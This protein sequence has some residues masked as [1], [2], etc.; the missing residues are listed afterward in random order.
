MNTD[1]VL[2]ILE[3][4][5]T[6]NTKFLRSY[7]SQNRFG[8]IGI[9]PSTKDFKGFEIQSA[10][11]QN[12]EDAC[13]RDGLKNC[14]KIN[15]ESDD[16]VISDE[17]GARFGFIVTTVQKPN[18]YTM[19]SIK[20][21]DQILTF[22]TD[23]ITTKD[24]ITL[25][26]PKQLITKADEMLDFVMGLFKEAP[27][28]TVDEDKS[29]S[30]ADAG[31]NESN[32][33]AELEAK[34]KAELEAQE[35]AEL[36]AKRKA[37][38]EAQEKAEL[39][40]QEKTELEA[41]AQAL[42]P[43]DKNIGTALGR[44]GELFVKLG[45]VISGK[46]VESTSASSSQ[47][48]SKA[49]NTTNTPEIASVSSSSQTSS[50]STDTDGLDLNVVLEDSTS[51]KP[52]PAVAVPKS[53]PT[54]TPAAAPIAAPAA[55]PIAAPATAPAT[56]PAAT[57]KGTKQ[58]VPPRKPSARIAN[59]AKEA[60]KEMAKLSETINKQKGKK[61]ENQ[62]PPI[63]EFEDKDSEYNAIVNEIGEIPGQIFK[64]GSVKGG[65]IFDLNLGT[66]DTLKAFIKETQAY[67]YREPLF[68]GL[69]ALNTANFNAIDPAQR[70]A[71]LEFVTVDM[72][73][74]NK[75][76]DDTSKSPLMQE[77][78]QTIRNAI[79]SKHTIL[80]DRLKAIDQASITDR[81]FCHI[82]D[83][84][85][86]YYALLNNT[87]LDALSKS[88]IPIE[89][90]QRLYIN[91]YM[92]ILASKFDKYSAHINAIKKINGSVPNE[93]SAYEILIQ[94]NT[95]KI[96]EQDKTKLV[97]FLK[98]A[99]HKIK[100]ILEKRATPVSNYNKRFNL[101]FD[102][103][104][105]P[106][107]LF[108]QYRNTKSPFYNDD[109]IIS[110]SSK[111]SITDQFVF[112][113]YNRILL[114]FN[115]VGATNTY[116]S[117]KDDADLISSELTKS[118]IN[119]KPIFIIGYGRSGSGKTTSLIY[120]NVENIKGEGNPGILIELL[121]DIIRNN[122][123][124][125][126]INVQ[127]KEFGSNGKSE[128]STESVTTAISNDRTVPDDFIG[129]LKDKMNQR[130]IKATTNNIVSSRS[131]LIIHIQ[132]TGN[133]D[134]KPINLFIGDFAGI[135][136]EFQ[137]SSAQDFLRLLKLKKNYYYIDEI[138]RSLGKFPF[139]LIN[140]EK[141][142]K[143]VNLPIPLDVMQKI[144]NYM[145]HRDM[146][147][148]IDQ[149]KEIYDMDNIK[150]LRRAA[151]WLYKLSDLTRLNTVSS[152]IAGYILNGSKNKDKQ[153]KPN[154]VRD[155]DM[156]FIIGF[157]G[158]ELRKAGDRVLLDTTEYPMSSST[159]SNKFNEAFLKKITGQITALISAVGYKDQIPSGDEGTIVS[160]YTK[161]V[162]VADEMTTSCEP[163]VLSYKAK[164]IIEQRNN[165][166]EY[167]NNTLGDLRNDVKHILNNR[168]SDCL[169]YAPP[170]WNGCIDD[171][172]P[173]HNKCFQQKTNLPDHKYSDIMEWVR[174]N[175]GT[176]TFE[177]EG[178]LGLFC[179]LNVTGEV[180]NEPK[181]PYIN[182]NRFIQLW[183]SIESYNDL[184]LSIIKPELSTAS[185]LNVIISNTKTASSA[186]YTDGKL[187]EQWTTAQKNLT[188]LDKVNSTTTE[189]AAEFER[190]LPLAKYTAKTKDD[191]IS[192][193]LDELRKKIH[194]TNQKLSRVIDKNKTI[195]KDVKDI[196]DIFNTKIKG[197]I[198]D[199][200]DIQC[201]GAILSNKDY[202]NVINLFKDPNIDKIFKELEYTI[203][204]TPKKLSDVISPFIKLLATHNASSDIGTLT[205]LDDFA[206]SNT[207]D[208]VCVNAEIKADEFIGIQLGEN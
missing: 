12:I 156:K 23:K 207:V 40:A 54:F 190:I 103:A 35:K 75:Y 46:P 176:T 167:I 47:T 138:N 123:N 102:D 193:A 134:T 140:Y 68:V 38:L 18:E 78:H 160:Y 197:F 73:L 143:N 120:S 90:I 9:D 13:K 51:N 33:A 204:G 127:M 161:L 39:E 151:Y 125:K 89:I 2:I 48:S 130:H 157:I 128:I 135:E 69:N 177:D 144:S 88:T 19:Y 50:S 179:V 62:S 162:S 29:G 104:T 142:I 126:E 185:Y 196:K 166:G 101:R 194:G 149:F 163:Y 208:S 172:C 132:V 145:K 109:G 117:N 180:K 148:Y 170:I 115:T 74:I 24:W 158:V 173:T 26:K 85:S 201:I 153:S 70:K 96:Q 198:E 178:V 84:I 189:Y 28:A 49:E 67:V 129:S 165:E 110:T 87:D 154:T 41:Q 11:Y 16:P 6:S 36:E 14:I 93:I 72:T 146:L 136:N 164:Q 108:L 97:S 168:N 195:T 112:G 66:T 91:K 205:F 152:S 45:N 10:T 150:D 203:D 81:H 182:I 147:K 21:D 22:D 171:Y 121:Y 42:K 60:D 131:H 5:N 63:P 27:T 114:P 184:A 183:K 99:D 37:E 187:K 116:A 55:A 15:S 100:G 202:T 80:T 7:L 188:A 58:P 44:F 8:P 174:T 76:A 141:E 65:G 92:D 59:Q 1:H 106:S 186:L 83:F 94:D 64:D 71:F 200:K 191:A 17:E 61:K 124:Y 159:D 169:Y 82:L 175:A 199:R 31:P 52:S 57:T 43:P 181:I 137:L 133:G 32:P 192:S 107:F 139:T 155:V 119:G 3:I 20:G 122:S 77:L 30:D 86:Y 4:D 79:D 105:D 56:A 113:K 118:M 206:K 111:Q 25:Y 34:R 53:T 95:E 98:I